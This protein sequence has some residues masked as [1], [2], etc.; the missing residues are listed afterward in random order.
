MDI[1]VICVFGVVGGGL[2]TYI[3]YG[4]SDTFGG[5]PGLVGVVAPLLLAVLALWFFNDQASGAYA[6]IGA[7][8]KGWSYKTVVAVF[9]GA[10]FLSACLTAGVLTMRDR[11]PSGT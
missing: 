2:L 8:A 6:T 7:A 10:W 5:W 1:G 9:L 3:A 4:V 11:K